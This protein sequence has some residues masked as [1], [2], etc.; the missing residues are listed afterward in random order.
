MEAFIGTILPVP[1]TKVP[2][3][4]HLCDGTPL[5]ISGNEVLFSLIGTTYGGDGISNFNVPDLRNRFPLGTGILS[6]AGTVNTRLG[7]KGGRTE[8]AV[9]AANLPPHTHTLATTDASG[10]YMVASAAADAMA[11]T[12]AALGDTTAGKIYATAAAN[13]QLALAAMT[14]SA[15]LE[16]DGT[17]PATVSLPTLP[18]YSTV[19]FIIC[20]QGLYP[21]Q[22]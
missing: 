7:D 6:T 21:S 16:P 10:T 18:L 8:T 1:Y 4:W 20:L 17:A 13:T 5:P 14:A 12:G 19:N 22:N 11:P 15:T 3:G 2:V 9:T